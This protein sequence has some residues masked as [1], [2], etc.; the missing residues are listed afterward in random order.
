MYTKLSMIEE[1]IK[2][3]KENNGGNGA[4][5]LPIISS[6]KETNDLIDDLRKRNIALKK[7]A[8]TIKLELFTS[9]FP[10]FIYS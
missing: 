3:K 1:T 2:R 10:R 4:I 6:Y 9:N 8:C 5:T 7:K